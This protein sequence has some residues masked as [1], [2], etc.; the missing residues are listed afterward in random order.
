MGFYALLD[1]VVD[2]LRSRGR[3]SYRALQRHF[4]LDDAYLDDLKAELIDAQH[5][6]RDENSSILVWLGSAETPPSPPFPSSPH[7]SLPRRTRC[8]H[9]GSPPPGVPASPEAERR[10][11][12]ILFCDLVASTALSRQLDPEDYRAAV[13]AYQAACAPVIERFNGH[14]AQLALTCLPRPQVGRMVTAV[15]GG[16]ALP[17]A[18][19]Q[20]LVTRSDG[21]PLFVE[22]L[23]RLVLTSDLL[24]EHGDHYALT[25]PLLLLAIPATLQDALMARLDQLGSAKAV[26]QLLSLAQRVHDPTGLTH[27]HITLGNALLSL[28]EWDAARPHLEQGVPFYNAQ[29]PR[30]QGFITETHQGV[31]GFRCLAQVLWS[32]GYPD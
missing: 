12:T 15:T 21:V 8:C 27:A 30:S 14:T 23:T 28:R 32:L 29:Q 4:G 19:V 18:G 2:L 1:Q 25:G 6:A 31:F 22:D 26:A 24:R 20:Q 17:A 5:L 11:L 10:Q 13:R 9:R 7:A 3:V 16:K